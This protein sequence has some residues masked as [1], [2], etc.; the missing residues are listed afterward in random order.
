MRRILPH[1]VLTLFL[2]LMWLMLTRFSLGQAI[3]GLLVALVAARALAALE[4][5]RVR[6]RRWGPLVPL[7]GV[8]LADIVAS[9]LSVARIILSGRAPA[10][11][12]VEIP[13]ATRDRNV[14][15]ILSIMISATPGTVWLG[16]NPLSGAIL[17]HVF[18][19]KEEGMWVDIVQRRYERRLREIFE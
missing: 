19:M 9:N 14:L 15:T 5:S 16:W 7:I 1:P 11:G 13:L 10:S 4:P 3:L 8:F 17:L 12:L 18:D 6:V 2:L